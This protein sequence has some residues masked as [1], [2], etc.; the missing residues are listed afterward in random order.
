VLDHPDVCKKCRDRPC[1]VGVAEQVP[2]GEAATPL[3][4]QTCGRGVDF[5]L[6][7]LSRGS[8]ILNGIA[9]TGTNTARP[10]KQKKELLSNTV[11]IN[12]LTSWIIDQQVEGEKREREVDEQVRASLEMFHDVQTVATTIIRCAERLQ[13]AQQGRNDEERFEAM[14]EA[15]KTLFKAAGL[16]ELR[17]R[18]MPLVSNPAA[19]S[20]GVKSPRSIYR[21]VHRL[22]HTLGPVASVKDVSLTLG[23]ESFRE[24]PVFE[25]FPLLPLAILENAIKYSARNQSVDVRIE[26]IGSSVKVSVSS[27][28]PWIAPDHRARIFERR[29]R[30]PVAAQVSATGSGLGLAIAEAVATAHNTHVLH[31]SD[32]ADVRVHGIR[33]CNNRFFFTV[34]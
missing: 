4:L 29:F 11:H 16:L 1:R 26:D 21:I 14:P 24:V 7:T 8:T 34:R 20:Y 31:Y 10:R 2:V 12:Q 5:G 3:A 15:A 32:D 18:S 19:A 25:S 9:V 17:V 22:K 27:F 30:A 28:S 6:L 13:S 23:G 33:Y